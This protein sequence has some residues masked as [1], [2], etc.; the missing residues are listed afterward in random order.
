MLLHFTFLGY[1]G[2]A[3]AFLLSAGVIKIRVMVG[4]PKHPPFLCVCYW[5]F[6]QSLP[7]ISLNV[8]PKS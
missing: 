7:R 8:Q 4:K 5:H 6:L 3:F 2:H 1:F